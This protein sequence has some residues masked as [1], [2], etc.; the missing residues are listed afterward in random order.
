MILK[1]FNG[2]REKEYNASCCGFQGINIEMKYQYFSF[3]VRI[4][5]P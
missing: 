5:K 2:L 3:T 4:Q 1:A